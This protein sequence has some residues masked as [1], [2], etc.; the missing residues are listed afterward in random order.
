MLRVRK[1][2]DGDEVEEV[3][4]DNGVDDDEDEPAPTPDDP[5]DDAC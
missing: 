1:P 4:G 5:D 2:C 3:E